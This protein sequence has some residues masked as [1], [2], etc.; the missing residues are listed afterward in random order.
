MF[1]PNREELAWAAGFFDGE[2][3]AHFAVGLRKKQT[4]GRVVFSQLHLN[5]AQ[6]NREELER[7]QKAVGVGRIYGPYT[8]KG[9]NNKP[10]WRYFAGAF[11]SFQHV[12][13]VLWPFLCSRKRAQLKKAHQ[14]F[15]T[16]PRGRGGRK[17]K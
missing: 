6:A 14:A 3:S 12:M 5:V 10:H 13:V 11:P 15:I 16:R 9:P 8:N 4:G 1:I 7:F 17:P 2:G